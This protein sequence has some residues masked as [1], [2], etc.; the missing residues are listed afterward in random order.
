MAASVWDFQSAHS[1]LLMHA[2]AHGGCTDTV[3]ES[4]P[5]VDSRRRKKKEKNL[6]HRGLEHRSVFR[7]DFQSGALAAELIPNPYSGC[8][9]SFLPY[10]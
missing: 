9:R 10:S 7:L 2:I 5:E 6:P 4:A 1:A 8:G 3:R